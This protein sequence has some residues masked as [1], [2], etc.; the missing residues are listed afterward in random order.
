MRRQRS[1]ALGEEVFEAL[2][3]TLDAGDTEL[4]SDFHESLA[5]LSEKP[6]FLSTAR[7]ADIVAAICADLEIPVPEAFAQ[8]RRR[9]STHQHRP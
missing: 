5:D 2:R 7:A 3:P 8:G 4:F 9:R 6:G 1:E